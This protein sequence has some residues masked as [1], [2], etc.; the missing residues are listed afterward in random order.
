MSILRH[1]VIV[2]LIV[3]S[4]NSVKAQAATP[5][6]AEV[7]SDNIDSL[8]ADSV[9]KQFILSHEPLSPKQLN[10]FNKRKKAGVYGDWVTAYMVESPFYRIDKLPF[11]KIESVR[12]RNDEDWVFYT[13]SFL[14]LV[15]AVANSLF[16]A[17]I[18]R[19]FRI[20]LNYSFI[21]GQS[22]EQS[23]Q[24]TIPS[25]LMSFLFLLSGA[26][27]I[28]FGIDS[29]GKISNLKWFPLIWI[30]VTLLFLIYRIKY[31]FLAFL[32]W[33]FNLK[34]A[35]QNYIIIVSL[36]NKIAGVFMLG[37]SV[38]LAFSVDIPKAVMLNISL[39]G[40]FAL[41]VLRFIRGFQVFRKQA[42][43]GFSGFFLSF[44]A[45]ELLPSLVLIKLIQE[46]YLFQLMSLIIRA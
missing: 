13:F 28:Y 20:F 23:V 31:I 22:R 45:V 16:P 36:V 6:I 12:I 11:R 38:M 9:R 35:F 34:E 41:V 30:S 32:G 1:F 3:C 19:L 44:I 2:F 4:A 24:P 21:Y 5:I 33:I 15:L 7:F 37:A 27:L 26:V 42:K 29:V 43:M 14:F 17:Y 39:F 46:E 18:G 8:I 25:I 10:T 40:L